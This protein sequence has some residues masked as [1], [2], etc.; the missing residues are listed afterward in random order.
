LLFI[1]QAVRVQVS[2]EGKSSEKFFSFSVRLF[3]QKAV[4]VSPSSPKQKRVFL[5]A[6]LWVRRQL[7]N[8]LF[9]LW[10]VVCFSEISAHD[11]YYL[12]WSILLVIGAGVLYPYQALVTAADY[13]DSIF[14]GKKIVYKLALFLMYLSVFF[15]QFLPCIYPP[16]R[17]F[18]TKTGFLITLDTFKNFS[19]YGQK[20]PKR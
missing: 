1:F 15:F 10:K 6:D 20:L 12:V 9:L 4:T 19:F 7:L 13:F 17:S 18:I 11:H 2:K 14:P 16:I 3:F 5:L 8:L